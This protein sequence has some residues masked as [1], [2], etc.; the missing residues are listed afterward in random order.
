MQ[1]SINNM[2]TSLV[3][4]VVNEYIMRYKIHVMFYIL[5][6]CL[7]VLLLLWSMNT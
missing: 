2:V 7:Q 4:V 1:C 5:I 6:T 3:I